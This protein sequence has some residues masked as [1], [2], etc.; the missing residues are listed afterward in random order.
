[1]YEH[2]SPKVLNFS[3]SFCSQFSSMIKKVIPVHAA[4]TLLCACVK[5][6]P[7]PPKPFIKM[8]SG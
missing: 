5:W 1:M 8:E 6:H 2:E 3:F 7:L 4:A